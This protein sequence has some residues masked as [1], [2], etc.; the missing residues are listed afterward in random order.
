MLALHALLCLTLSRTFLFGGKPGTK[1][2]GT[3]NTAGSR[4]AE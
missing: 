2:P 4:L 3:Y 1:R